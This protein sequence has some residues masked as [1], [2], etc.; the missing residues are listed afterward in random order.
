MDPAKTLGFDR[1]GGDNNATLRAHNPKV[2]VRSESGVRHP[3][4]TF[5]VSESDP[6]SARDHE[7]YD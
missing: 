1:C 2:V 7:S 3:T 5:L 6:S 4:S